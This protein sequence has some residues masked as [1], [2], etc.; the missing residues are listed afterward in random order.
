MAWEAD[1]KAVLDKLLNDVSTRSLVIESLIAEL[2]ITDYSQKNWLYSSNNSNE[3]SNLSDFL[4]NNRVHGVVAVEAMNFAKEAIEA[5]KD[6]A[7]VDYEERIINGLTGKAKCLNNLL[8]KNENSFIKDILNKFEGESEFDIIIKSKDKVFIDGI[9]SGDGVNGKTRYVIGSNLIN[10]EISTY[11]LSNVPALAATRTLIHE[12]IHAD[13]FR[14]LYTKYPTNG[15]LDFKTT[16]EK[17]ETEKQHNAMAELYVTSMMNTLKS[18]HKN[19]LVRDYNYLTNN[20]RNPLPDDFYEA[21][22]WQGLK[23]H[24][25]KA[26]IDLSNSKK[27]NLT[28]ALNTYY[29]S[30]TK[31]CPQ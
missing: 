16:Y 3:V 12:Y 21:L 4:Q 31:N 6:G 30:T 1:K 2:N 20:G 28:N 10:I 15:D 26:Y 18:F 13:M 19:V 14:K 24:N 27:T 7:E 17:Y 11:K 9:S 5:L 29:H 23:D 8:T 22:A 25:V